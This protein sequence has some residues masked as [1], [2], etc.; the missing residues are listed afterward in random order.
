MTEPL[1]L[2]AEAHFANRLIRCYQGRPSSIAAMLGR[3]ADAHPHGDALVGGQ[4]RF[5]HAELDGLAGGLASGLMAQ[6]VR[7]GD[8]VGLLVRN[9]WRFVLGLLAIIRA[10]AIAVPIP[11]RSS[12]PETAYIL[13]DAEARLVICDDGL[14]RLLPETVA[15]VM[16]GDDGPGGFDA[17]AAAAPIA[18][19]GAAEEDVAVILYTSGTTGRPKGAMLTHL[20]IVHSCIGYAEAFALGPEDRTVVA[21]PASHVTGLIAGVFA[22]LSVGG[23]VVMLEKFDVEGFLTLAAAERMSFTVMV[24]AMYNLCL[25]RARLSDYD[26]SAWRVGAFGGAPMPVATIERLGAALPNLTLAQAYGA[27]ETTSP[28]TIMPLGGQIS[29]PDSVG[30]PVPAADIRVMDAKGRELHAGESGE[31]WIAGPMVVPGYWRM[32]EKTAESFHSG[33][34]KSGDIGR[35]D[36]GGFLHIH[37]RLKDMINRGGYKVY[38]AEV[39]NALSFHRGVAEAAVVSRPDPILGEKTHAFVHLSDPAVDEAAL[40]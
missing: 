11:T 27:T 23:A 3:V 26:L 16:T 22:P 21:V 37:D 19:Y 24:P 32:P 10:G 20:N 15:S 12:A 39:E 14:E 1:A 30:A 36:E 2:R 4:R 35:M 9:R 25:L 40:P 31:I 5:S 38:S 34:W 7:P 29:R 6:G 28:A 8:R 18:A 13:D 17:M 33:Y